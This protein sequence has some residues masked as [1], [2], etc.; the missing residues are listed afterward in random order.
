MSSV[1]G[2]DSETPHEAIRY[3]VFSA[4]LR[5]D[6]L[7][8]KL[9]RLAAVTIEA[10]GGDVDLASMR[11]FDSPSYD[12]DVQEEHGF[13]AGAESLQRRLQACDAFVV[14]SPEYNNSMPGAL[15]NAID[16][17]SR[18]RPQP[19]NERHGL[20]L[21]ASPSMVGGNRGCGRCEFRSSTSELAST[22][23]CSPS[24][25]HTTPYRGRTNRERAASRAI[26]REHRQ[27]HGSRRGGEAL[28][29]CEEGV[30][31]VPRRAPRSEHRSSP[32]RHTLMARGSAPRLAELP[33]HRRSQRRASSNRGS[34]RT[35]AKSSSLRASSRNRG[36]SST[37]RR[38]WANVSSPV[39]PASVASTRS[40][41]AD[42]RAHM[43]LD[44]LA[45]K[46]IERL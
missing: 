15:K 19:F 7:N 42:R 6:S 18:Y 31:R 44:R 1:I 10:R 24:P 43:A 38:S 23:T 46:T 3:L 26:R 27:L 25:G 28:P 11:E 33:R 16:W 32:G 45:T 20:L 29:V 36:N 12:G 4:S 21:S 14:A 9:A 30:G 34:S 39:S 2:G 5:E 22:R 8:M 41:S 37:D 13:P 35:A 17:V 40:C